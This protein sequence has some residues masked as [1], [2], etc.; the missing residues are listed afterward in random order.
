MI[1]V[2]IAAPTPALRLGLRALLDDASVN[3]VGEGAGQPLGVGPELPTIDVVVADSV[4]ISPELARLPF[5][6]LVPDVAGLRDVSPQSS[7]AALPLDVDGPTLVAA[8]IAVARGLIVS[9]FPAS[10]GRADRDVQ[11][12]A[13]SDQAPA[14]SAREIEVL[15]LA[16]RG[17]P[18]KMIASQL[19]ISESTVKYHLTAIYAKLGVNGRVEAVSAAARLGLITL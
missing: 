17:L 7:Y 5:V 3:I 6:A 9:G 12:S 1:R 11:L 18:S 4:A 15:D 16:G 14:L 13:P 8:V 10:N 2:W 19:A